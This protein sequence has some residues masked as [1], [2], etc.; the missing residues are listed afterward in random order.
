MTEKCPCCKG[1]S[2]IETTP[3]AAGWVRRFD[4]PDRAWE[5]PNGEI[6]TFT[7]EQRGVL[8]MQCPACLALAA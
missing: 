7:K 4:L 5:K 2:K 6:F 8:I 3:E 1:L